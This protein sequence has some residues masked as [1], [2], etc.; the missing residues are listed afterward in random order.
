MAKEAAKSKQAIVPEEQASPKTTRPAADSRRGPENPKSL[1]RKIG[2]KLDAMPDRIDIRDWFYQ[3]TLAS[4]PRQ[5]VNCHLVPAILDQGREGACT[6]FALAAVVNYLLH[7]RL[8]GEAGHSAVPVSAQMLYDLARRYDE[9]PGEEYEGSSARGAMKAWVRH[10]VCREQT[11]PPHRKGAANLTP[12]VAK[13]ALGVPGG[14]FYRVMH[15][16]IR[17]MH[18]ALTETGILYC[19]LMVHEG[20]AKPGP[21]RQPVSFE[22]AGKAQTLSLPIIQRKGRADG[23]HAV[24]IVGYTADGFIIQNSWG[25]GWGEKGFALLPYGDYALHATDVWVAQLGV[26]LK[27]DIW[28]SDAPEATIGTARASEVIPLADIRPYVVDVGNNG[29]LSSTGDYWTTEEDVARLFNEIIPNKARPWKKRRVMLFLH[30]G[31]NNERDT[32]KRVLAMRDVLLDNEIYPVHVMWESGAAETIRNIIQDMIKVDERAG[33][34]TAD[35]LR[36]FRDG[37]INAT[38]WTF[39]LTAAGPGGALWREMKDNAR[40]SSERKDGQGAMQLMAKHAKAALAATKKSEAQLW[41]LHVV[42]HSA[43]CIFATHAMPH[44]LDCG[45]PLRSLHF[46][47]PAMTVQLFRESLLPLIKARRCPPPDT[48]VL[49]DVGELDDDVGPYRK[50]LLYLVSNAFEPARGTPLLGMEKFITPARPPADPNDEPQPRPWLRDYKP[51]VDMLAPTLVIAGDPRQ[52]DL[53]PSR[54]DSHGGFDNDPETLNSILRRI[55]GAEPKRPF[56]RRDLQF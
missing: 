44:L 36:R 49:S 56:V 43:G 31:L 5:V 53:G 19:T 9:W 24:A 41:E 14:A 34:G 52:G 13:E 11:W 4:L 28:S 22:I 27:V 8:D 25:S 45:I 17:D 29:A 16:Q 38:D 51:V 46:M 47:A 50:S 32:A 42:A 6:G 39:E 7:Q 37:L 33:S 21:N 26:P 30:G 48:Y 20:W 35:W 23:G 15:R 1:H 54:S 3:P 10:G 40:L 2:R 55:L 18:A 12:E